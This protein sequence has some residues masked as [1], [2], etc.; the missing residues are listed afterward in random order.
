VAATNPTQRFS[1]RVDNYIRYRPG[2]PPEVLKT[3]LDDCGLLA[4]SVVAD[5]GCG[6][7]L[8]AKIF[9]DH[10][11]PVLGVEPNREMRE[12][13]ERLLQSYPHFTSI[14]GTAEATTLSPHSVDFI[15]AGQAAH[16]FD[17]AQA[18]TEFVR[19]LKPRGWTA[20]IWNERKTDSSPFLVDYE[21]LLLAYGTDYAQVRHERTTD[22]ISSFFN[23]TPFESRIFQ[24]QQQFDYESLQGRLLS[25]SYTPLPSHPNYAP[26][27]AE[28]RRLFDAHQSGGRVAFEYETRMFYGQLA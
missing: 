10:G 9:L 28:L 4:S 3:L 19:I 22:R 11:N 6:T 21:N 7:G 8:L 18:R 14:A 5:I 27:L 24:Y 16:W 17:L 26:M 12:A 20:L 25:S 2:Y 1:S 23:P 15:T 13:G